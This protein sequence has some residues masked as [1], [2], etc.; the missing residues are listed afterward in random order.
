MADGV[1]TGQMAAAAW[2]RSRFGRNEPSSPSYDKDKFNVD[3]NV[4]KATKRFENDLMIKLE[5]L[6]AEKSKLGMDPEEIEKMRERYQSKSF[7]FFADELRD[8]LDQARNADKKSEVEIQRIRLKETQK[9]IFQNQE[10]DIDQKQFLQRQFGSSEMAI[11]DEIA[12]RKRGV[13]RVAMDSAKD[14]IANYMDMRSMFAGLVNNNPLLMGLYGVAADTTRAVIGSRRR[15]KEQMTDD[16]LKNENLNLDLELEKERENALA[17]AGIVEPSDTSTPALPQMPFSDDS[18]D[19]TQAEAAQEERQAERE[20]IAMRQETQAY[21]GHVTQ[22]LDEIVNFLGDTPE[23]KK[24]EE[25]GFL[26]EATDFLGNFLGNVFGKI[27]AMLPALLKGIGMAALIGSL[28]N[29]LFQGITD[30]WDKFVET[31]SISDAILEGANSLLSGMTFGLIDKETFETLFTNI[32]NWIGEK[33]FAL[34]EAIKGFVTKT[35]DAAAEYIPFVDSQR[36]KDVN[37]VKDEANYTGEGNPFQDQTVSSAKLKGMSDKD[38][39]TLEQYATDQGDDKVV[40]AIRNERIWRTER[41]QASS[42]AVDRINTIEK[43]VDEVRNNPKE[44]TG[45]GVAQQN[46]TVIQNNNN[47]GSGAPA[48]VPPL[49]SARNP[50]SA[51]QRMADRTLGFSMA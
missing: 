38:L 1:S 43:R 22:R 4:A 9:R 41:V 13:G 15:K 19:S 42:K 30:G 16:V 51:V 36:E 44:S 10:L 45:G 8:I 3:M 20:V 35:I 18:D 27:T 47:G 25:G 46:N 31:G 6:V 12:P 29:G 39:D 37:R 2:L 49:S 23:E 50:D 24:E 14:Q 40:E 5:T 26:S 48:M 32:G 28:V 34:V 7:Q 33:L 11:T 21:R 17:Q